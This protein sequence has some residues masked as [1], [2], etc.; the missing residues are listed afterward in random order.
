MPDTRG[1]D[2]NIDILYRG[3][4]RSPDEMNPIVIPTTNA[5]I[6]MIRTANNLDNFGNTIAPRDIIMIRNGRVV[7]S[8]D[9]G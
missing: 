7:S 9:G 1:L 4:S 5:D 8:G 3:D 6:N 2:G